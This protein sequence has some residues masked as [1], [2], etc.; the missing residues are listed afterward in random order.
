[1]S[2]NYCWIYPIGSSHSEKDVKTPLIRFVIFHHA[3]NSVANERKQQ[4]VSTIDSDKLFQE[5]ALFE[6]QVDIFQRLKLLQRILRNR[7]KTCFVAVR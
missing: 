2:F 5:N 6:S 7:D 3:I 4:R 1:M